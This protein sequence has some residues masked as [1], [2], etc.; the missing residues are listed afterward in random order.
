MQ[1]VISMRIAR[2]CAVYLNRLN[3]ITVDKSVFIVGN[4]LPFCKCRE[5]ELKLKIFCKVMSTTVIN[6]TSLFEV[7]EKKHGI[8][9]FL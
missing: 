8:P 1:N 4:L 5:N 2:C 6:M 9:R 7:L 3:T